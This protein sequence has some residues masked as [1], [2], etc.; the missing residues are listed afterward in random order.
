MPPLREVI[1]LLCASFSRAS[2]KQT[3]EFVASRSAGQFLV[4]QQ[5]R[6]L[7]NSADISALPYEDPVRFSVR[8]NAPLAF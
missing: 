1:S 6:C 8:Y 7:P 3:A 2:S 5:M 4:S